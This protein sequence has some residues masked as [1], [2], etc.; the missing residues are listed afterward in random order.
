M[1]NFSVLDLAVVT[2]ET[3][4]RQALRNTVDL[5]RH[6][7]ALGYFRYWTA[8]HHNL[9]SVASSAPEILITQIAQNTS[10]IRVG[11]GGIMLPNHAPL[12]IAERFRTLEAFHPGRIDLGIGRAPGT[13]PVTSY[14]LRNRLTAAEGDD[15]LD[16]LQELLRFETGDFPERH[17]FR[18]I[19]AMPADVALPPVFLLGS[20]DYGADLAARMGLGFAFAHHFASHDATAALRAYRASFVHTGWF[21]RPHAILAV[22]AIAAETDAEAQR[23]ASSADLNALRRAR[24]EYRPLPSPDEAANYVLDAESRAFVARNRARLF[25]GTPDRIADALRPLV[26]ATGADEVMITTPV[27]DHDA[28]KTSYRLLSTL[29]ATMDALVT[30]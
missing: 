17:P 25:V 7:D 14:A 22:A 3:S 2:S 18:S 5:A 30:T 9:A 20:S 21:E 12:M 13:D 11:S 26:A 24:G 16:R 10:R 1:T 28:R 8:E 19:V 4:P 29:P 15:F 27:F 23:L 6:A